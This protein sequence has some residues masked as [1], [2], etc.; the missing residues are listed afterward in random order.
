MYS[1][2]FLLISI[3]TI[4]L[5]IVNG[6]SYTSR[7]KIEIKEYSDNII[8]EEEKLRS[9][10]SN[11]GKLSLHDQKFYLSP[12]PTAFIN[13]AFEKHLPNLFIF[14]AFRIFEYQPRKGGG[15]PFLQK[16]Q[17]V[18]WIFII[19][20]ILS[21]GIIVLTY[22]GISGEKERGSLRLSI[23]M[24]INRWKIILGKY[25]GVLITI[26]IPLLVGVILNLL[27]ITNFKSI[28]LGT[29]V[30]VKV[31]SSLA[32]SFLY[33]SSFTFLGLLMS[34]LTKHS[35]TSL[36]SLLLCW[37]IL[38]LLI[39]NMGAI[40]ISQIHS[41]PERG[42]II[43][44]ISL[45]KKEMFENAPEGTWAMEPS[46]PFRP[47][48]K[49][50]A[51]TTNKMLQAE[52]SIRNDYY[53]KQLNQLKLAR[54][55]S[56]IS[57]AAQFRYA[58]ETIILGG[59]IRFEHLK[60]KLEIYRQILLE[61]VKREDANDP[62]SPHWINP[63]S[64]LFF[65]NKP[66]NYEI[67]PKFKDEIPKGSEQVKNIFIDFSLLIFSNLLLLYLAFIAFLKYDVR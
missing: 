60:R 17:D 2:R 49:V 38:V 66:V 9:L 50:R 32:L 53:Q 20:I 40:I 30:L 42:E 63:E 3:L 12:R 56:R 65:T 62:N 26:F 59:I 5:F 43:E 13:E 44:K 48:H 67:I 35:S 7:Y 61:F 14:N 19:S 51:E 21:F 1:L 18:D 39:P 31:L 37:A 25:F 6:I 10:S 45:V 52:M 36:V 58:N 54:N 46:N 22:D 11:L 33:I 16:F 55:L 28:P 15:N 27:I 57:P 8:E 4:S 41:V 24:N 23:S 64:E 29:D 34:S 47:S